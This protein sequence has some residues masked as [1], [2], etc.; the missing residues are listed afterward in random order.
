MKSTFLATLNGLLGDYN[1]G[2]V[3]LSGLS[4]SEFSLGIF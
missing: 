3:C 2:E 4:F 1:V